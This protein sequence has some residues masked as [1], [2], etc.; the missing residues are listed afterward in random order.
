M[1]KKKGHAVEFLTPVT[2]KVGKCNNKNLAS[3]S[4]QN[5]SNIV[6]SSYFQRFSTSQ[7]VKFIQLLKAENNLNPRYRD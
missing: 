5:A 3:L 1:K 2:L 6:V 4:K 7:K